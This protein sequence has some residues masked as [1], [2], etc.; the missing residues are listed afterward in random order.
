MFSEANV[1]LLTN[2]IQNDLLDAIGETLVMTFLPTLFAFI[3]GMPL[4]IILVTGEE[5]GI[6][7]LP[8]LLMRIINIIINLL[9]SVP[10]LILL[11]VVLPLSRLIVGTSVGTK[12]IIVPLTIAAFPFVARL[13]ETSIREIDHGV[14]EAAQ[15]MGASPMQ[16]VW[17]VLIPEA[18]PSLLSNLVTAL[19]TIFGYGAMSGILGGGGIGALA[20][21]YGYYRTKYLVMY[22]MV[23]LLIILV[24]IFQSVGNVII[25]RSDKRIR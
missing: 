13:V 9:R 25:R 18:K 12:A 15:A 3:I 11:V 22:F 8:K 23:I 5:R 17:K 20:I 14:I 6:R 21:N 24:Q 10:F 2:I 16:I 7:P 4:G 19:I 1:T